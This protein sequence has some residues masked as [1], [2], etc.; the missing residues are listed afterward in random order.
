MN[1]QQLEQATAL[2]S[3]YKALRFQHEHLGE[4]T[5]FSFYIKSKPAGMLMYHDGPAMIAY[6]RQQQEERMNEI[7]HELFGIGVIL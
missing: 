7:A 5:A 4:V 6:M 3:E 2:W 1:T